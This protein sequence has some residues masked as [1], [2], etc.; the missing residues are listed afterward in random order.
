MHLRRLSLTNFRN[1]AREELELAPGAVLFLGE[2]AQGKTNLLEAVAL[3]A[4]GR[5]ERAASDADYIAWSARDEPQPFARVAGV[6]ERGG[7]E[8]SVELAVIGREGAHGNLVASKRLKLNGVPRRAADV[9][10]AITAVLF[11]TDDME[12]VKGSPSGRRRYLDVMLSQVD[13]AYLR[14]LPRYTKLVTQRNAL[15]KRI[16]DGAAGHDELAYW[17]EELARDGATLL[18]ARNAAVD[19]LARSAAEAHAA[20]S[21]ERER[22]ELAYAPRFVDGWTPARVAAAPAEDVARALLDKL[23]ATRTRDVAAGVTLSG[24]HRD[25][26]SMSIG[27]EPAAAFAS[28]GQQR[29]AALAL[30]LAEARLLLDRTGERPL[31]LLDDVLSE[32]DESRRGSVLAA[33]DAD[34]VL[35]TSPDPDR[36]PASYTASVQLWEIKGGSAR[37]V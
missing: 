26:L 20:L 22:F 30:R 35:I 9:V 16:Q 12:L 5:S 28:R 4:T 15:L 10:G 11:T 25:D 24:P 8:V 2:N 32:L 21:G 29:T 7:H 23:Q 14:A 36:F 1:Y 6:A 3:L 18:V 31:L 13:R 27:G 34:Q 17:D 33:I 19:A 37:R